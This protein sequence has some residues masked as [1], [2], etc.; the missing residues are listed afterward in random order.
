MLRL[1]QRAFDILKAEVLKKGDDF[2]TQVQR[3]IALK[4]WEKLQQQTGK[5]LTLDE[6]RETVSDL[7]PDFS[8]TVLQKA[9]RANRPAPPIWNTIKLGTIAVAGTV[10]GLWFLNLPYP[11]IRYPVAK[12]VPII[13]LPSYISMDSN[14]RQAIAN[15]EQADQLVNQATSTAD[16]ELGELKL[17]AAQKNLDALPV[18]FLGYY[19]NFYMGW[20]QWGWRFTLDEFEQARKNVGRMEAR[21]FQEKNAQKLLDQSDQ[22]I[23]AA[24]QQFQ[25][26]KAQTEQTEAVSQWQQALDILHQIPSET[27]AGRMAK[28]KLAA[29]ERDFGQVSGRVTGI[30]QSDTLIQA[31]QEF[32]NIAQQNTENKPHSVAEW[33]EIQTFWKEAIARLEKI[34][35]KNPDYGKAQKLMA[36]Y[37][38]NL[39]KAHIR[40]QEEETAIQAYERANQL[41]LEL[42]NSAPENGL[43][44]PAKAD[45]LR[46]IVVELQRVKPGTTVY[47]QAQVMQQAAEKRLQ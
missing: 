24:K 38:S 2:A 28:T 18:W 32:A 23:A 13:L 37:Q 20:F 9:A 11:M 3:E 30:A 26:A 47:S 27:L 21:V 33:E 10:G 25:T 31:A 41:R 8:E 17:K 5:P 29:Y 22:A 39:A 36:N 35:D 7:F 14:Y 34:D 12:T 44:P 1:N 46:R 19:P 6:L 40:Q 45:S 42:L 16:L 4:R 15:T 43:L